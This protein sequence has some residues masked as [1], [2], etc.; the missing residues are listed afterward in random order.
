MRLLMPLTAVGPMQASV[1]SVALVSGAFA[2][3]IALALLVGAAIPEVTAPLRA[4]TDRHL[5][6]AESLSEALPEDSE[7]KRSDR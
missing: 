1:V 5:R 6:D 2:P 4:R 3:E 7:R